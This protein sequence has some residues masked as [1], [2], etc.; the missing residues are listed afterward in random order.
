MSV[1]MVGFTRLNPAAPS[2]TLSIMLDL[3]KSHPD[4]AAANAKTPANDMTST[5]SISG[6]LS[7]FSSKA[8]PEC[9]G[10]SLGPILPRCVRVRADRILVDGGAYGEVRSRAG[11]MYLSQQGD[12]GFV[13]GCVGLRT[14]TFSGAAGISLDPLG[15]QNAQHGKTAALFRLQPLKLYPTFLQR[16][17]I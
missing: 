2:K 6:T 1:H 13:S 16:R 17:N 7:T 11:K 12:E 4:A 10:V 5:Q 15:N 14:E 8:N 9:V 3:L